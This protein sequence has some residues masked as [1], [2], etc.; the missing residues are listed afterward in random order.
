[1]KMLKDFIGFYKPHRKLFYWDMVCAMVIAL[2]DLFYPTIARNIINVYVPNKMWNMFLLWSAVLLVIYLI[3]MGMNYFVQY[4]G[5][6][7]S[8]SIEHDMRRDLFSHI[9]K[10]SFH[11]F[12]NEKTG[13][14]LSRITSDITEISELSFRGPNDLLLCGVIMAG[15]LVVML[16]MN[17]KLALLIGALLVAKAVHTVKINRQMKGAFRK[18][19]RMA[20]EVAA[21]AEES[22]SGI[23]L[24][25][26]FAREAFEL[27]RFE[28]KSLELRNTKFA[29]YRLVGYFSGS[30]NFFT[31]FINVVVILAGGWMITKGELRLS[32]F[33][34]FLLYVN[35]FMRPVF[36]LTILA[37]VYQRGMAGFH[38]F[39][40]I[41]H[42]APSIT[43]PPHPLALTHVKGDID[44]HDLSFGYEPDRLILHHL[45]FAIPAGK[46]VAFVGETGAGKS[47]LVSLLLRFYEPTEGTITLDGHNLN[48]FAQ[49]D[50]RRKIGI[51]QQDVFLFA[52]SIL[53][54]I[55]YGKPDATMDEIVE[56]A[57]RAE[58]YD[59]ILAMP[60]GFDTYVGERGT[61]LSG[62]QKQ[63][64]SIARIFLK[65]P[66]VLILDEATS[67]I[68]TQTEIQVQQ[69]IESL[70]KGRTSFI[71]AHRLSTIKNCDRILYIGNQGIMEAG[72]HDELMAKRGAYYELYT[73]QAR[74]QGMGE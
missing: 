41:M 7:M 66:P 74:D 40:E 67:S 9:E 45:N 55:R 25:K 73:A 33:V 64:I 63:R 15:T 61:L 18:N 52:A 71:I 47:T 68:D 57:K 58:I 26:A 29:S 50:L 30:I 24:V 35:I 46:T 49:Q 44:F 59:D 22:L 42:T 65:N 37:E 6:V 62:G 4:Y 34:A 21:R 17:W 8:A 60:D 20:G 12:D 32:D 28:E 48:E 19:R 3:K 13:Q 1:M 38:R 54:N 31:N 56:A 11:Y 27:S 72:S 10:L 69:G 5:H 70:L 39:E 43:D 16:V 23:R 36:R 53:E 51:V 14:L 2:A